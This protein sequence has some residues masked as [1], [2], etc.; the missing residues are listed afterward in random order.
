MLFYNIVRSNF[1]PVAATDIFTI[2]SNATR[3][4]G[5]T[6]IDITGMGTTSAANELGLFRVTTA[7]VTGSS[8]IVPAPTN[9][10]FAAFGGVVNTVWATQPVD[11]ATPF[12]NMPLNNAGQRYQWTSQLN[13]AK[14]LWSPGGAVAAGTVSARAITVSGNVSARVQVVEI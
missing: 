4:F 10:A 13:A 11:A 6:E 14:I 3:S 1:L 12:H 2:I 5:I 7:G 9:P 8:P